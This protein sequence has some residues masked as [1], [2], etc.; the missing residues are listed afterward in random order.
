LAKA[1]VRVD[2]AYTTPRHNHC[3]IELHA[4]TVAWEGEELLVHDATQMLHLTRSTL[5]HVFGLKDDKVRVVRLSS[6]AAS[7]IRRSGTITF[8]QPP[9]H[10][11]P[12]VPCA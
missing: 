3:A 12:A 1:P 5:A 2:R 6:A 4:V 11:W 7:A 9:R 8:L 10:G